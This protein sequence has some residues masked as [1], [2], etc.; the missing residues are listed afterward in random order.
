MNAREAE[1][2]VG[3]RLGEVLG[4]ER[5]DFDGARS[6]SGSAHDGVFTP[7]DQPTKKHVRT[8]LGRP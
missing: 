8:A 7:G 4:L 1:K 6:R 2:S 5:T 3:M